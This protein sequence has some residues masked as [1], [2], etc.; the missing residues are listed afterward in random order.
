MTIDISDKDMVRV[1]CND[2]DGQLILVREKKVV[3]TLRERRGRLERKHT[4]GVWYRFPELTPVK[5]DWK[6][7]SL[8]VKKSVAHHGRA[9]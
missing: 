3:A 6:P 5:A 7:A 2:Q 8:P 1:M 9:K 4:D